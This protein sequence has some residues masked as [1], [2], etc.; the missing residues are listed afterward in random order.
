M[1][2]SDAEFMFA[3]DVASSI[4]AGYSGMATLNSSYDV[5]ERISGGNM[6]PSRTCVI[7][8]ILGILLAWRWVRQARIQ[9]IM[10]IVSGSYLEYL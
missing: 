8:F 9:V 5:M 7:S 3:A 6:K 4:N 10:Y 1:A 2:S